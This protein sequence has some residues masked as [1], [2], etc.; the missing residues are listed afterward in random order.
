MV[1]VNLTCCRE[2]HT[3]LGPLLETADTV[4]IS[5]SHRADACNLVCAIIE[6]CQASDT[7]YARDAILDDFIW[8]RL[9]SVYLERSDD[10][11]SKSTRQVLLVLTSVLLKSESPRALELRQHAATVFINII[12]QRQ[13]RLKVKPALQ[14]L[15]HFLGKDVIAVAQLL[16]IYQKLLEHKPDQTAKTLPAQSLLS[17]FLAWV[18]HHDTSLSAGHLIKNYLV[19]LRSLPKQTVLADKDIGIP[20]WLR[21]VVDCLKRW[22]DRIQEFKT[23]VFPHCF[24]PNVDEYFHFLSFLGFAQHVASRECL[25]AQ[26]NTTDAQTNGLEDYRILLASI[27]KGK[28]LGIVKDIGQY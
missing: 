11:K 10:A 21:S 18:V 5:P 7:P 26:L 23:H 15:A 20:L 13:D 24:L 22:P 4:D 6:K 3:V 27:E 8:S 17:A 14:G 9:F 12:C 1:D 19:K 28:E 25:P 16:D 2:L